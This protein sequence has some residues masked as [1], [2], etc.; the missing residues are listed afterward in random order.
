MEFVPAFH[1]S[2]RGRTLIE[3]IVVLSLTATAAAAAIPACY[4]LY[5]DQL[6][7]TRVNTLVTSL[8]L[9]RTAA[10]HQGVDALVCESR[11]HTRCTYRDDWSNGWI[12]FSDRNANRQR[13]DGEPLLL[14]DSGDRNQSLRF[15]AQGRYGY[16]YVVFKPTG[17]AKNGTFTFCDGRGPEHARAVILSLTGRP[18]LSRRAA[19]GGGLSCPTA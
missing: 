7:S 12:V 10:I 8:H 3:L 11:D 13:D 6:Q 4:T 2:I 1:T 19:S 9:A 17:R 15:A 18:R 14:S 5:Q 16:R